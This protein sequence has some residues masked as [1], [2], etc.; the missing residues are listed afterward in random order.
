MCGI[1]YIKRKDNKPAYKSV[2]KRYRQQQHRGRQGFGYVAIKD[3]N[4]VGYNRSSDEDEIIELMSKET[5]EEMLFHHRYPT[6]TPNIEEAAH[7]LLVKNKDLAHTYYIAHNGVIKKDIADKLKK[8]HQEKGLEYTTEFIKQYVHRISGKQYHIDETLFNDSESIAIET[9]LAMDNKKNSIDTEG[10]AAVIGIQTKGNKVTNR[11]FYRNMGNPLH[12]HE[13]KIMVC[14]T[15]TG[16][17]T[18]VNPTMVFKLGDGGNFES[19]RFGLYSPSENKPV[20]Y[21][22]YRPGYAP[23]EVDKKNNLMLP[24]APHRMGFNLPRERRSY[25]EIDDDMDFAIA[26]GIQAAEEARQMR[27]AEEIIEEID[28]L[29]HQDSV[30]H[31]MTMDELCAEY[32]KAWAKNKE[33][34]KSMEEME[35]Y[36]DDDSAFTFGGAFD[37]HTKMQEQSIGLTT[38]LGELE[39][40]INKRDSNE[41]KAKVDKDDGVALN[42]MQK[43]MQFS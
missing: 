27:S 26:R 32:D 18:L 10:S 9:A 43:H 24:E 38:F 8:E 34:K 35:A 21:G 41:L 13:D 11:F 25:R 1:V 19:Y 20:N 36:L 17:G 3:G 5:A 31:K 40:E 14:I 37:K 22:G 42:E 4:V 33:I 30:L 16:E 39:A 12:F 7:P 23:K 29:S 15:S 28:A 2:L 6:S